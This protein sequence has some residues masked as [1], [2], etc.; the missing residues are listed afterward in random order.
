M[1]LCPTEK[2]LP[3]C[4]KM[5][6]SFSVSG[7]V[8]PSSPSRV[9]PTLYFFVATILAWLGHLNGK[10]NRRKAT[11]SSYWLLYV[12]TNLKPWV[13]LQLPTGST[14]HWQNVG[15]KK[16]GQYCSASWIRGRKEGCHPR[17]QNQFTG[18][19]ERLVSKV[20]SSSWMP[21][22]LFKSLPKLVDYF[23]RWSTPKK[24]QHLDNKLSWHFR[25]PSTP[26]D[27]CEGLVW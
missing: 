15:S 25:K 22:M 13:N 7:A 6:S 14:L 12:E 2:S 5:P 10:L 4:S 8:N 3:S 26:K 20:S 23:L 9:S 11:K 16:V 18:K 1:L 21:D 17:N 19:I 27:V 24:L